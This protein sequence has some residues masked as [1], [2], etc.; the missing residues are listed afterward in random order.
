MLERLQIG[1]LS[2]LGEFT[3]SALT[4][5]TTTGTLY[6]SRDRLTARMAGS[7]ALLI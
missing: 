5:G 6:A 1:A 7:T 3:R 4:V 2:I